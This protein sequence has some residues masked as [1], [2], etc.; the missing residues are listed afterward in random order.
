MFPSGVTLSLP[1]YGAMGSNFYL[2][3]KPSE[4]RS[5]CHE[6]QLL[7]TGTRNQLIQRLNAHDVERGCDDDTTRETQVI[8]FDGRGYDPARLIGIR[9][10]PISVSL[11]SRS[12]LTPVCA[13]TPWLLPMG[14]PDAPRSYQRGDC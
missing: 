4:L 10:C 6:R 13:S 1:T 9:I 8:P 5:L 12:L 3:L 14:Q 2:N 11:I 7:T